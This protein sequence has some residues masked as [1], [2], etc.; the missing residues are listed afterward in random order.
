MPDNE[1]YQDTSEMN[2]RQSNQ[3]ESFG[4]KIIPLDLKLATILH[5]PIFN[6]L[7]CIFRVLKAHACKQKLQK[8]YPIESSN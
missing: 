7:I 4:S 2:K 5:L 1:Y 8:L 3:L 6:E